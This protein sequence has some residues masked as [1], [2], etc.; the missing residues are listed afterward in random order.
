MVSL[1]LTI[2]TL[3]AVSASED[4]ASDDELTVSDGI[5]DSIVE[6]DDSNQISTEEN[7]DDTLGYEDEDLEC[8]I[9]DVKIRYGDDDSSSSVVCFYSYDESYT[10]N[11]NVY[12]DNNLKYSHKITYS[13]YEEYE[14]YDEDT[15]ESDTYYEYSTFLSTKDLG[16]FNE[17]S[18]HIKV[19]LNNNIID[20]SIIHVDIVPKVTNSIEMSVGEQEAI[21]ITTLSN[22][23]GNAKLYRAD[24]EDYVFVAN[25][26]I[27]NGYGSYSLSNLAEGYYDF[28]LEYI[29]G[30]VDDY[31]YV[32]VYVYKNSPGFTSSVTP[33]EIIVGN[34]INV[35]V[36]GPSVDGM[37]YIYDNGNSLKSVNFKSGNINEV[38][39]GLSVGTHKIKIQLDD[40][41]IYYSTTYTVNVKQVP[42]PPAKSVAKKT[43]TLKKVAV[44]KSAKKLVL[45]ATLKQGKTPLKNKK[46][47]F[48]FNGK[49]YTAKTNKKGIAK[50]T[51]KKKILKK[52]KVGKKIK[53]QASYGKLIK[54][55]TVKV[56]K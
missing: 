23:N 45:T 22:K 16:I 54:K 29:I 3:G 39:A 42:A 20:Q 47:T 40:G 34:N 31:D 36:A 43:L 37:L 1:I 41:D 49:K 10:G 48:K 46:I 13:D 8:D 27:S 30:N 38:L 25:I 11:L 4:I 5:D 44:K 7:S 9:N 33:S 32:G 35:K 55:V 6:I 19:T 14:T 24:E 53:Y 12:V 2:I 15:D 26:P 17:G 21:I 18:Y 52:L 50:V 28:R 51:I 56:K